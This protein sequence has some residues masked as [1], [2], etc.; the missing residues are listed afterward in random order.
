MH[1]VIQSIFML[2][3]VTGFLLVLLYPDDIIYEENINSF[4][5]NN[6]SITTSSN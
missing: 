5:E 1:R 6:I 3:L 4:K 2:V